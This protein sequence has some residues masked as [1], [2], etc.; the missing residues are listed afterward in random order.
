MDRRTTKTTHYSLVAL[1]CVLIVTF[2]LGMG[3]VATAGQ[4]VAKTDAVS[5]FSKVG[6]FDMETLRQQYFSQTAVQ[7]T[8]ASYSGKRWVIVEL[9]GD[10]LFTSYENRGYWYG[11]FTTYCNSEEGKLLK[12]D[13]EA[14]HKDFLAVLDNNRID[15]KYKYSY[16]TLNNG[17]ALKVDADTFNEI[18]KL[19]GVKSVYYSE[20]YA[21]PTVAVS[22]NANVYTTGIYDSS[23]L[24]YKGEGMVVAVLDTG[25]DYSH[26][27]FATMPSNPAWTKEY[28][29]AK[30]AASTRFNAQATVDEVYYNA[31]V[32][33]A[34][35]YADDDA[36]VYP[37][38]STHGT[39]VAGI[40]A[41]KS[42]YVV[43]KETDE[44][45]VGV[46]PE[47]QL[48]ICKVFTDNL[49][50]DSLGGADTIDIIAAVSDC[51]ELGVD[52]I[53]MSLGSSAGFSD[54]KSDELINEVYN[55]V[56]AAGISLVVAASNDYSSGFGGGNGTNLASNPDSGTVGSPSTYGA[57]LSVASINGQKAT[58]I[59]ANND[60]NQVAFITES[61]DANGNEYDFV[62]RLYNIAGKSK[63]DTLNFKYVVVGGVG[64][65]T[66][67][68]SKIRRELQDKTG[69]DGT[70]ALIKRGDTTFADKVQTAMDNG[71]DAVIIYNNLSGTIRMSL[72]DVNNP[73]PTCSIPMDAG[74][75]FVEKADKG[76]GSVQ[77]NSEFK[78]G[79]FMSDFSS[80]G[81]TPDLQL[82]PEIT[83][84]G[85]E[86]TSAVPG[87]Y[88][89][90]SGTSMAAPNM[91]GAVAL[92][93][94]H[95]KT[96]NP[97]LTGV[98]LN[99]RV[100]Q[101][102]MSTA[103]IALNDEGNPYSPR[104]QGAGLAGIADAINAESFIT[105]KDKD[106]NVR[107]KT[108]VELY[109]DKQKTG[110]YEFEFTI[111]NI[112]GKI[113]QYDP[114][115]Y[116]M[117]ETLASDNKTVA[118]KAYMLSDSTI[119]YVVDGAPHTGS[120][121]VGANMTTTVKVKITLSQAARNYLDKSF[122][123]G[124]YVEG[125]VS[126]KGAD[127]TKVTIGLPYFAFYGDWTDAPL[128][129]YSTYELA[130]SQKD[131]NVPAEDKLVASAADTKVIGMYFDD[132]YIL[133]L[134][135][136]LY[137]MD[138][139]E[140][141][142][143]PEKEKA[144]VSMFDNRGQRT[145]YE[146]YMVYAGLLR[147]AAYMNVEIKDAAT[148]QVIYTERQ[149]NIS[150]S[151]AAGGSNRAAAIQLEIK[152]S[153][154]NLLNNGTYYVSLKGELDY[155]GGEN[156]DRN[157]FDFQFTVDY[158]APQMLDYRIRYES[159][160][161]NKKVKYRIYMDVDV[162]DNQYVQ[163]VMPC[164]VKTERGQRTL[165]LL[166]EHPIPVYGGQGQKSTVSFDITDIYEDY[167][168]TGKMY[169][170]VEDYA[171]NQSTY[172][173]NAQAGLDYPETVLVSDAD[174]RLIDTEETGKNTSGEGKEYPIYELEIK[175]NELFTPSITTLP[176]ATMSQTLSWYVDSGSRF[177][178]VNKEEI[179]G[180]A[181]GRAT[182]YL[183]D[184]EESD[185]LIYARVD[186]IVGEERLAEPVADKIVFPTVLNGSGYAVNVDKS[187][188]DLNPGQTLQ[189]VASMSP[190][191]I[192]NVEFTWTSTNPAVVEIDNLG[193]ITAKAKGTAYIE[194]KAS[195]TR[196][197]KKLKIVVGDYYR[198]LNYTLYDY[199][200]GEECVIPEDK[201][202]MYID[203]EC[204]W[205]NTTLKRVVLPSTLTELPKTAFKGCTNLEEIVIPSQCIVIGE[206][207]FEGCTKLKTVKFG[208]FT[209]RDHNVSDTYHGAITIGRNAFANC[210]SLTTIENPQRITTAGS[211]AFSGCTALESIDIS[212]LRVT[213][214]DVFA[215]CTKLA[216][217]TTSKYTDIGANMFSGCTA[218]KN[219][220]FKG[221]YLKEGAFN[222]CTGLTSFS[223]E[224][225]EEFL[226]I[227]LKRK[228]RLQ[229]RIFQQRNNQNR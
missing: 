142:I 46:A 71:A 1:I 216:S 5:G 155:P 124:M 171:M 115:V 6:N 176:D 158:E 211:G 126:L 12:A 10:S 227:D 26:E 144:A 116:V 195:G 127:T 52:V 109:D 180:L 45:F 187:D 93:R 69:Y 217:V 111:N 135:A 21:I 72:G 167:I 222:G 190:W 183:K 123:N 73:V 35:D 203:E 175:Q 145:I 2:A 82:K 204:F 106:G 20:S 85:G 121:S 16:S 107:D 162:V 62:E 102:L 224:P 152:P 104:K 228:N 226:G 94:Q 22:N 41:G 89:V 220:V 197:S 177:V 191:Y 157:S 159:Y 209:D 114:T 210:T 202:V 92:L 9:E 59:Q 139:S 51:V 153:E 15:Y 178:A 74:K 40:V 229:N 36:D 131:T 54:E 101:V 223:F 214:S 199:Y 50:S 58:F 166:T 3:G 150:K 24:S 61:S 18:K 134:G 149:E 208:M 7:E 164:Y 87:G 99:A 207:A 181:Q 130:E 170:A 86:I 17:V 182:I 200:G 192:Q 8:T 100:N 4:D 215:N 37:S 146:V 29:A 64:R 140:V 128:F 198:I 168:K 205:N 120:I 133:Q 77:I 138:E 172:I 193:N 34:Y 60:E 56:R 96:A 206:S 79:P 110:I 78:A 66:N 30:M 103:T 179:F 65:A 147:G 119:E 108:K 105:V 98:E 91:S 163:D 132:K 38:Y 27:A 32:P 165:T 169:I 31:K 218:L 84:H 160:T 137:E 55:R 44:T 83:A 81:P 39:H 185:S 188:L 75:V 90:Y 173:I 148:G 97:T 43:N 194:A 212:E 201:N 11:D 225:E 19:D 88:D 47:A 80:W 161:E 49:D 23:N 25:L 28:V 70:I 13:I 14:S 136:Y 122:K 68:T 174:G 57:A 184:G 213:G 118:E 117:T 113:E 67:Y 143:Y 189:I 141:K 112:S 95:L 42:D 151:Y 33:F 76:V 219:F 48:V 156:P 125:F 154:W 63:G 129:D 186:V 196:L 53:N 221:S